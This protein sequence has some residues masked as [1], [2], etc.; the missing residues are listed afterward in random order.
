MWENLQINTCNFLLNPKHQLQ[1]WQRTMF[2]KKQSNKGIQIEFLV[3]TARLYWQNISLAPTPR[4]LALSTHMLS[5]PSQHVPCFFLPSCLLLP[6]PSAPYEYYKFLQL[7]QVCKKKQGN[8]RSLR[9]ANSIK[10]YNT[11]GT[12]PTY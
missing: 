11:I 12:K 10:W 6:S 9:K 8:D 2:Q 4:P 5:F 3:Q 1:I 7:P